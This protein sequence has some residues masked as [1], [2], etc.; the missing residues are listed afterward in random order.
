M[1]QTS[2]S[3]YK[4]VNDSPLNFNFSK[5]LK[6]LFLVLFIFFGIIFFL[7]QAHAET[8]YVRPVSGEYGAENGSTYESAFDGFADISWGEGTG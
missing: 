1:S 7:S 4:R 3:Q 2:S 6:V 8:L 5:F